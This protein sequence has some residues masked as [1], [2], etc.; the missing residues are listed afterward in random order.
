MASDQTPN[1]Q[2]NGV[3][4]SISET[5]EE[6]GKA[7]ENINPETKIMKM[8]DDDS[9]V[10][11]GTTEKLKM[12]K[13]IKSFL[14]E[15]SEMSVSKLRKKVIKYYHKNG[16]TDDAD[17]ERKFQNITRKSSFVINGNL[18]SLAQ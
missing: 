17:I 9:Q 4:R 1:Q 13:V 18:I 8:D 11:E 16:F 15:N 6:N 10:Q 7:D 2:Q 12:K 5:Q 14:H 3:K